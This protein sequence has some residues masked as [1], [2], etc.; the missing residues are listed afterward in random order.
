MALW[1][2][3][4]RLALKFV[5]LLKSFHYIKKK[6]EKMKTYNEVQEQIEKLKRYE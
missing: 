3:K 1:K 2:Q 4:C 6:F 5:T